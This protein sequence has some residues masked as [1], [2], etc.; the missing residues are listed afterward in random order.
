MH[1]STPDS[2]LSPSFKPLFLKPSSYLSLFDALAGESGL[3]AWLCF[4]E[5]KGRIY[6]CAKRDSTIAFLKHI[7]VHG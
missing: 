5:N 6:I 3:V 1:S 4:F 2:T 7:E